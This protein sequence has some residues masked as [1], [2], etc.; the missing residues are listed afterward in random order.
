MTTTVI[1]DLDGV[2][3]DSR[4]VFL[5][6][7]NHAFEKLGLPARPD[8]ELLPYIGPPFP[9]AFGELLGVA[10]DAPIVAACIDGYR[11]RYKDA[12]LT[13]T[14]ISPGIP[15]ALEALDGRRLAVATS[16]PRAFAEPILEALGLREHFAVVAG[17]ELSERAEPKTETLG[18]ALHELGPTRAVMV[19]DRSFDVV[20]A[21]AHALPAIGVTWGIGT[22]RELHDAGAERIIEDPRELSRTA[23]D[24][25]GD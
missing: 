13:E 4:A 15:E 5:R 18:R 25:L 11:E 12:S 21:H 23:A 10:H 1:F 14:T 17:P 8:A 24:L 2:L 19:G 9:Y 22:P 7:V 16:K 6:C 3:V 20:A